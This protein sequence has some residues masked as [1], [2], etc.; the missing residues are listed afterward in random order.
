VSE[1]DRNATERMF[2]RRE[3][4]RRVQPD[5]TPNAVNP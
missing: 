5:T 4:F 3:D 2:R 1:A